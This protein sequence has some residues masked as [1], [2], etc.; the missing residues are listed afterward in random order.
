M[1]ARNLTEEPLMPARSLSHIEP[2]KNA[3]IVSLLEEGIALAEKGERARA[4]IMLQRVI[5]AAPE[6]EDAWL[7]L[8]WI[9]DE[10]Q[11]SRRL[12]DEASHLIPGSRRINEALAGF[13]ESAPATSPKTE[14]AKKAIRSNRQAHKPRPMPAAPSERASLRWPLLGLSV[15]AMTAL[16]IV[17]AMSGVFTANR[18]SVVKALDLP[19]PQQVGPTPDIAAETRSLF[20]SAEAYF[21][22]QDWTNAI[23]TLQDLRS[24]DPQH[25]N[26]RILL[27]EA[28]LS[29]AKLAIAANE[30]E[31]A[32][33]DLD[34]AIR[35]NAGNLELQ[36]TRRLLSLYLDGVRAYRI[37]DWEEVVRC[38]KRV[39]KAGA[40]YRDTEVMLAQGY[41]GVARLQQ[42]KQDYYGA[43]ASL[44]AALELQPGLAEAEQ[45]MIEVNNEI[46]PPKRVE[47][48]LSEYLVKVYENNQVIRT[49]LMCDGRAGSPTLPG[50]YPVLFKTPM[51][52]ASQWGGL[53]MPWWI[54]LYN[55][56]D[57][58]ESQIQNGFHAFPFRADQQVMWANSLGGHCSYGCIV[59]ETE[60]AKWLYDW[61]DLG[62]V[63]FVLE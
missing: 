52:Q 58:P 27:A 29:R 8:A 37:Q 50:R 49:F 59:L 12:L 57:N 51:A 24:L 45:V 36:E 31:A 1:L 6:T 32:Q 38:L 48:Y 43:H 7:W 63:V 10:A 30:L 11:E 42:E 9:A 56:G 26:A 28:Y 46:T 22:A 5:S 18:P 25:E 16:L 62:T 34:A 41:L 60:S 47:V 19:P 61:I 39:H 44:Q 53:Q 14:R 21:A 23:K 54:G 2:E 15:L 35:L 17:L 13:Q 3:S 40:G 4:R 33:V 20:G 55:I